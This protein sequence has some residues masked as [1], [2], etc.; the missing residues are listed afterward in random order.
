MGIEEDKIDSII[1]AHAE[2]VDGLTAE[3]DRLKEQAEKVP[4][5][6]QQLEEA[7]AANDNDELQSKLDEAVKAKE[8]AEAA[9]AEANKSYED[10]K[11]EVQA[12]KDRAAKAGAYRKQVLEAAGI[13][14]KY[15][16]DVMAV[17]QLNDIELDDGGNI[18]G[19]AE[20]AEAAKDK[21]RSFVV[22]TNTEGANPENPPASTKGGIEG[23]NPRAIQI[24]KERH[25]RMYGK[26]QQSEE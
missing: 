5:L 23:A 12:E 19:A 9:L 24:A 20:L 25:E 16:D 18:K 21:W 3:R 13:S 2:T 26:Q 11:A 6:R 14:P 1:E 15:L 8:T 10:F 17:A 22:K 4:E 7:Q